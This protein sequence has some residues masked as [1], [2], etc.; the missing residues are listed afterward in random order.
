L[1][2]FILTSTLIIVFLLVNKFV[3]WNNVLNISSIGQS[4]LRLFMNTVIIG[5]LI[6]FLLSL[7]NSIS[8]AFQNPKI[9]NLLQLIVNILIC[10]ILSVFNQFTLTNNKLINIGLIYICCSV[11]IFLLGNISLFSNKYNLVKPNIKY[12]DPR[13]SR[14]LFG[15]SI[16]FFIIQICSVIIFST[17]SFIIT[18]VLGPSEATSYQLVLKLFNIFTLLMGIITTPLWSAYT[19]ALYSE[20]YKWMK[21]IFIKNL[22]LLIPIGILMFAFIFITRPILTIWIGHTISVDDN[23]VFLI[24]IYTFLLVWINIFSYFLNGINKVNNQMIFMILGAIINIPLSLYFCLKLNMGV[25]GIVLGSII[26]LLFY[27]VIAPFEV[28]NFF[29]TQTVTMKQSLEE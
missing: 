14:N 15:I 11:L 16:K 2:M 13:L 25:K 23:L 19:T 17:D 27:A 3:N 6:K 10:V 8:Y 22:L 7:I 21:R 24:A 5:Y 4:S 28:Y 29:K 12:I 20:N 18:K 26:A 1:I 9:A